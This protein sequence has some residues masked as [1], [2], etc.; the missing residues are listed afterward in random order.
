MGDYTTKAQQMLGGRSSPA[1]MPKPAT[2]TPTVPVVPVASTAPSV[3]S[4]PAVVASAPA[5]PKTE[6][7]PKYDE[8]DFPAAPKEDLKADIPQILETAVP[9][10][11]EEEPLLSL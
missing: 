1:A 3:P 6:P 10:K 5:A 8:T 7:V 11:A 2:S 4:V 9:A